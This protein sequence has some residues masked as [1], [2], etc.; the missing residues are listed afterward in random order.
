M[1]YDGKCPC[2]TGTTILICVGFGSVIAVKLTI[3]SQLCKE[4]LY[5]IV[6]YSAIKSPIQKQN[7]I[8]QIHS[9]EYHTHRS[10]IHIWALYCNLIFLQICRQ[11][12]AMHEIIIWKFIPVTHMTKRTS[13]N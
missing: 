12:D 7:S 10:N 5:E 2:M 9:A 3:L 13:A 4:M 1:I 11:E 6:T 8:A